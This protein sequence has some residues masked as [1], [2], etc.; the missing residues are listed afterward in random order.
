[1]T[2][3]RESPVTHRRAIVHLVGSISYGDGG[4][5]GVF[6]HNVFNVVKTLY[7]AIAAYEVSLMVFLNIG[8]TSIDIV[9]M[10]GF[11]ELVYAHVQ[12]IELCWRE[13]DLILFH[14]S[15]EGVHFDH[16][17]YHVQ[18]AFNRPV[19]QCTQFL[20]SIHA[21]VG[22]EGVLKNF[23]QACA[24]RAHFGCAKALGDVIFHLV[25]LL[26]HELS[27]QVGAHFL[28]KNDGD[29]RE[30]ETRNAAQV[31]HT[32]K[33]AHGHLHRV[34]HI[35]LDVG[36]R[37]VWRYGYHLHLIVGDIGR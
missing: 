5:T 9:F 12:G 27:G 3:L 16:T 6:H 17:W 14:T 29:H 24:N 30:T 37:Q 10:Q 4:S 31:F 35:L 23:S 33:V 2:I 22:N 34:G 28:F 20:S 7:N 11:E 25:E 18:L 15:A 32:W 36:S 21:G 8:P 13:C 1:M 19:L 26:L